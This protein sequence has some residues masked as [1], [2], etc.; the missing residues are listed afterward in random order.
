MGGVA[1][2][3]S[4]DLAMAGAALLPNRRQASSHSYCT[5][6]KGYGI[7]VGAGLPAMRPEKAVKSS[8]PGRQER[9]Q[10][11]FVVLASTRCQ[12]GSFRRPRMRALP[13]PSTETNSALA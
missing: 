2:G 12:S 3:V 7:P 13:L 1:I 4:A 10:C 11:C 6:L 8:C 5:R 9:R